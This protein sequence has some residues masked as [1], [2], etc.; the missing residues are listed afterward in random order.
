M[1]EFAEAAALGLGGGGVAV[2][3]VVFVVAVTGE[4]DAE[5]GDDL[6]AGIVGGDLRAQGGE[7]GVGGEELAFVFEAIKEVGEE[8]EVVGRDVGEGDGG[9]KEIVE[10]LG[11]ALVGLG[12]GRGSGLG[13]GLGERWRERRCGRGCGRWLGGVHV[14][15]L[16]ESAG[17]LQRGGVP[18]VRARRCPGRGG[19]RAQVQYRTEVRKSGGR[20]G[21]GWERVPGCARAGVR[22]GGGEA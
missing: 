7:G 3:G 2:D 21:I 15:V 14:A 9:G 8:E 19:T 18:R 20:P 11:A 13:D 16:R 4:D 22:G 6:G 17:P 10:E 5:G 1:G 12:E